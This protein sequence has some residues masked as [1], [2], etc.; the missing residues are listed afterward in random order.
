M[1]K[2]GEKNTKSQKDCKN[3]RAERNELI[4]IFFNRFFASVR[5]GQRY[6]FFLVAE[7]PFNIV[8]YM[9]IGKNFRRMFR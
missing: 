5:I 6:F 3:R 8:F 9:L 1:Q 4:S 2:N 7:L